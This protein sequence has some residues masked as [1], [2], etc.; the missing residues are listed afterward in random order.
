MLGAASE[1]VSPY[2]FKPGPYSSHTIVLR[3]FPAAGEG[4]TVLDV[5]C[6]SGYLSRDLAAR[7]YRVTGI[8]IST[9]A[10]LPGVEF[11]A[12]DLDRGL[13]RLNRQ[14]DFILCAD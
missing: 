8:D 2:Q 14:F 11:I 5:G 13:P 9:A 7:G 4:R 10:G 1:V 3:E 6:A 12:A